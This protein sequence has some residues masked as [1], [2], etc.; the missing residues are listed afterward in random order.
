MTA[1]PVTEPTDRLE[2]LPEDWTR[3]LAVAAHPDDLEYGAASAIARWTSQGKQVTYLLVTDG[4]AGIDGMAPSE[5]GPLRRDEEIASAAEVGVDTVDFLGLPDGLVEADQHTRRLLA[6]A[7]RRHRPEVVICP[8]FRESWGMP[9]W[10]HVDHRNV[11]VALLDAAR[12]AGNRWIFTELI[13]EGLEPWSGVRFVAF[14]GSPQSTHAVDVTDF[15]DRGIASLE[16]HRVY[17]D[18]LP[19]GTMGTDPEA[20]LRG[21]GEQAGP[22]LGVDLAVPFEVIPV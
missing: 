12:D 6:A 3:A 21:F 8:N 2:P 4:E 11:G 13:G 1:E 15:L 16:Q 19:E 7:I 20:M 18:A 22:R 9:S 10:N 17:L 5:A 14:S